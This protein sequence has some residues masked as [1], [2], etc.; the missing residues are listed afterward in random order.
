MKRIIIYTGLLSLV[1]FSC[2]TCVN[3]DEFKQ[4]QE[5]IQ[6]N[7]IKAASLLTSIPDCDEK[8][9][10]LYLAEVEIS[11]KAR[12]DFF[13][14]DKVNPRG[15]YDKEPNEYEKYIFKNIEHFNSAREGWHHIAPNDFW[16]RKI[17]NKEMDVIA[18]YEFK[19]IK[20]FDDAVWEDGDGSMHSK[21]LI[22]KY[23]D[24]IRKFPDNE[25]VS[26]TK[27][28]IIFLEKHSKQNKQIPKK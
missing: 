14:N 22:R 20:D 1:S 7:P 19:K 5:V 8:F 3:R 9:A 28:R 18:D 13:Y 2:I 4:A 21:E 23:N 24:W 27:E 10:L 11:K 12:M 26:K 16:L 15:W 6:I 25:D 17:K